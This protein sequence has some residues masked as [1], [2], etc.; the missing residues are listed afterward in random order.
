MLSDFQGKHLMLGHIAMAIVA[1]R[2]M[3]HVAVAGRETGDPDL[4]MV[5]ASSKA[6][7][8]DV[9]MQVTDETVQLFGGAGHTQDFLVERM[10]CDATIIQIYECTNQDQRIAIARNILR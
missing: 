10:M 1:A 5:S 9:A 3:A 4:T 8:S 6:L 2:R 7:T